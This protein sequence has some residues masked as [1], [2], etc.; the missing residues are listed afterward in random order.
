MR[1]EWC[2]FKSHF[3]K[4]VCN[5]IL[6]LSK[7]IPQQQGTVGSSS[8][9]ISINEHRKSK[10]KFIQSTNLD[11]DAVFSEIWKL[12]IKAN[13]EWFRFNI[14]KLDYMQLA[15]YNFMESSEY[16]SHQ[17]VFWLNNDSIY[18]RKLTCVVQL[19][20]PTEYEGGD[21]ELYNVSEHPNRNEIRQ[22]GTVI[23]FPS[24]VYHAALPITSGIRN[25]LACWFEGTKWA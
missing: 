15:E 20:N 23:F 7:E 9:V 12:A 19:T 10:V 13:D 1:G 14:S 5:E 4:D 24:F 3:S 11:Y 16:K 25:S 22:Q 6:R 8:G 18:H 21:L 2:Y 17:D